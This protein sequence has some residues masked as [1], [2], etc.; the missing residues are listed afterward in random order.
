MIDEHQHLILA[1]ERRDAHAAATLMGAHI[2]K[3]K[4]NLLMRAAAAEAVA[5]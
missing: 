3:G 1:I 2:E 5:A 4:T